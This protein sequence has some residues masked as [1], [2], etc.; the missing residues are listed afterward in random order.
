MTTS[1]FS[2]Y[3]YRVADLRPQMR[4]HV[5]VLRHTYRD[6]LWY[7]L[8]D[9][10]SGRQHRL[11]WGAFQIVGRLDGR[12]TTQEIWEHCVREMGDDAPTQ[13]EVIELFGRLNDAELIQSEVTPDIARMF[14]QRDRRRKSIKQQ[15]MNPLS[16]RVS[17]GDPTKLLDVIWPLGAAFLKPWALI[18]WLGLMIITGI[19]VIGDW[20]ALTVFGDLHM[21]SPSF[22]MTVWLCY[23]IIKG[24]HELAHGVAVRAWGGEVKEIGV[25]LMLLFPVPWI[26]ASAAAS[27]RQ[28]NR[29][30]WVS[31]MGV[32]AE[33]VLAAVAY[34]V[35]SNAIG[36]SV[37]KQTA[38]AVMVTA[39]LS[40]LLVNA[41]PLMKFDGYYALTDFLESPGLAQRG[42][43]YCRYLALRYLFGVRSAKPPAKG[44]GERQW[45]ITYTLAS[46]VYQWVVSISV[47]FWIAQYSTGL[48]TAFA[49]WIVLAKLL[50]PISKLLNFLWASTALTGHRMRA[51]SIC[52]AGFLIAFGYAWFIPLTTATVAQGVV[53]IPEHAQLRGEVD[54]F[55]TRVLVNDGDIVEAGA[56]VV[57]LDDPA[58]H[59]EVERTQSRLIALE[60]AAQLAVAK[61]SG[62]IRTLTDD[63]DRL[64]AD[65]NLAREKVD[66]LTVRAKTRG[67]VSMPMPQDLPGAW[68]EKGKV[69]GH[70]LRPES[71][72][73]RTVVKQEDVAK[74]RQAGGSVAVRMAETQFIASVGTLVSEQPSSTRDLPSAALSLKGGG[75]EL[76]DPSDEN[77]LRTIEPIFLVD[78]EVP[79][80]T[81]QRVGGRVYVRFEHGNASL[82]QH[83]SQKMRQLYLKHFGIEKSVASALPAS[84]ASTR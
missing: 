8:K 58:L 18:A 38:F 49:L 37:V 3:W 43:A 19:Y 44:A 59:I 7:L 26:D 6:E 9:P 48:A 41:N 56:V 79:S 75:D 20:R 5:Q 57:Q 24:L 35:W 14:S 61:N 65:L 46:Q 63:I 84:L 21:G 82:V 29:R 55:V 36:E 12:L 50:Q 47:L 33:L 64:Q 32:I 77:S 53:W 71:T 67:L 51:A 66:R 74:V 80:K 76:T 69:I 4:S 16:F 15:K 62:Q 78:V 23:P 60:A 68:V 17:I 30:V 72:I 34:W 2:P 42:V 31:L 40:T 73:I 27:F 81:L 22:L 11:S 45:L 39:G 83:A 25:T 54:G 13:A 28:K 52:A 10:V 1:L 70:I